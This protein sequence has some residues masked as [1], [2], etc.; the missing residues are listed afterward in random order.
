VKRRGFLVIV[1]LF[2]AACGQGTPTERFTFTEDHFS[3]SAPQGWALERHDG[4]VELKS[5]KRSILVRTVPVQHSGALSRDPKNVLAATRVVLEQLP[6][7]EV[8]GP[9]TIAAEGFVAASF[10]VKFQP[11]GQARVYQRQHAVLFGK[12]YIFHVIHT[13]LDGETEDF[14]AALTS[15]KEEG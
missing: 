11:A 7:G 10:E 5:G 2:A 15:V 1:V 8:T 6:A 3:I 12:K 9:S 14:L 13:S 4:V